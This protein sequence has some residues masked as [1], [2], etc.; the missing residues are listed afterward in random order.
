MS[1]MIGCPVSQDE[2]FNEL[3]CG[4]GATLF[5]DNIDQ[6]DDAGD[7]ATVTDLLAGVARHPGWRAVVTGGIGNDEWKTKLPVDIRKDGIATLQ[8]DEITDDETAA[9]SEENQALAF[10]LRND[11]PARGIARNSFLPV[12]DDRA[13]CG[14]RGSGDRYRD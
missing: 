12:A 9:L 5:I 11:H 14:P 1:H 6:I 7:W 8:V 3:G 4:G 13:W 10:I 2:L